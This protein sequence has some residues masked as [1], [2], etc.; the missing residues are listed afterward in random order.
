MPS[1]RVISQTSDRFLRMID[2]LRLDNSDPSPS[3]TDDIKNINRYLRNTSSSYPS[4]GHA[5]T[6]VQSP[7]SMIRP[8]KLSFTDLSRYS[9]ANDRLSNLRSTLSSDGDFD[10]SSSTAPPEAR[11]DAIAAITQW[12]GQVRP[13]A[14]SYNKYQLLESAEVFPSD[15]AS[16][17]PSPTGVHFLPSTPAS[18]K[19]KGGLTRGSAEHMNGQL[20]GTHEAT[21]QAESP[22]PASRSSS[23]PANHGHPHR[24]SKRKASAFSLRSLTNSLSKRPRFDIR[25][26]AS[27]FYR[28]GSQRLNMARLKWRHQ[29]RQDR[30]I[31]EAWRARHRRAAQNM[32]PDQ[33]EPKK[34]YGTFSTERKV[35][36]NEDWWRDGVSRYE[37]PKWMNFRGGATHT[38]G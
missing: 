6:R 35:C 1:P 14:A 31:F 19:S 17:Q 9:K 13:R 24:Q 27:D 34:D 11:E 18:A 4:Q 3:L 12:Q 36:S 8:N 29:T 32:F 26:W 15:S 30:G 21:N 38:H 20:D 22:D 23:A 25:K 33:K 37:A 16:Q 5:S 28:Q 2:E 7:D 10:K